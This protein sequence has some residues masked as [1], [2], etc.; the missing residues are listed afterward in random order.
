MK[1]DLSGSPAPLGIDNYEGLAVARNSPRIVW[2][3][4]RRPKPPRVSDRE[5]QANLARNQNAVWIG[6]IA[7]RNGM[8]EV[9]NRRKLLDCATPNATI[10]KNFSE[11]GWKCGYIE[12]QNF[13]P[14]V[15]T[16]S[17]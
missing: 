7:D 11:R 17:R 2:S 15:K 8:P 12:P 5:M 13:V 16:R 10:Q 1:G 9:V 6:E 14:V 4:P 3:E